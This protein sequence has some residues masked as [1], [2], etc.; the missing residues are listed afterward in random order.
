MSALPH[1]IRFLALQPQVPRRGRDP[2]GDSCTDG[3]TNNTSCWLCVP[4]GVRVPA[5]VFIK[6]GF[7][8]R[9]TNTASGF[10]D[11]GKYNRCSD[12]CGCDVEVVLLL[13]HHPIKHLLH[14]PS[15]KRQHSRTF[16]WLQVCTVDIDFLFKCILIIKVNASG[17]FL[18]VASIILCLSG[19]CK[20][21]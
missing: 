17:G 5:W 18:C 21:S 20:V 1:L 13:W 3:L 2:A 19:T 16:T 11:C 4:A 9:Q 6:G 10:T 15:L 14:S 8:E 12:S 7:G